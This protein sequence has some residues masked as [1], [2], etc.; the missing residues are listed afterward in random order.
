MSKNMGY[1][2][3][4]NAAQLSSVYEAWLNFTGIVDK[5][6]RDDLWGL[7]IRKD[8]D[9]LCVSRFQSSGVLQLVSISVGTWGIGT[10]NCWS[11]HP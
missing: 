3:K 5:N 2:L 4:Y 7:I 11:S 10:T 1:C 8:G 9:Q 6:E